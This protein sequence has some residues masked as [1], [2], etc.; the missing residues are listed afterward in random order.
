[1]T[2]MRF[3]PAVLFTLLISCCAARAEDWPQF[4]GP[5]GDGQSTSVGL[6]TTWGGFRRPAWRTT[7][8]GQGWSSPIVIGNRIWVTSAE[9]LALATEELKSKLAASP[10]HGVDFQ[11]HAKATMFAV[12][13]EVE[14]G[15][16]L[17][18]I[19]LLDVADPPAIHASNSYASP[20][21]VG[22]GQRV[23]CHFGSLGTVCFD[24][25]SGSILWKQRMY[26]DEITGPGS[27]P[28]LWRDRLII[29]CDGADQQFVVALDSR[30]GKTIWKTARPLIVAEDDK[31]R[32]AFS[33]PLVV[34]HAGQEQVIIPGAQ[35]V[36]AYNPANG[37]EL[38]RVKI[39][40]GHATA[41]R[42]V[43]Y[44]GL[45]FVCT[46]FMK[47]ELW[48]IR[49]DGAGDVS[50]THVAWKYDKQVPEISSPIIV[51]EQVYFT[52]SL[53]VLTCL[54]AKSGELAW[55]R[56]LGGNYSASPLFADGKLYFTSEEGL[57]TVV[58]PGAEYHELARNQLFGQTKA[59]LAVCGQS[60]L[61][62]T[63]PVLYCLG[64][65]K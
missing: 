50:A 42:P 13:L 22:D 35:W 65:S 55:Q 5:T 46:G 14:N 52:S 41:P 10:A 31:L 54:N 32:R 4:R 51:G 20:T 56:R 23:Y 21:P 60:L 38:W 16:I 59:S 43:A 39:G 34:S 19:D 24:A 7:I 3:L 63:D 36:A 45:V 62:R 53:G 40:D 26:F 37:D 29:P 6:P 33:T 47:P 8:P 44:G 27:S 58:A 25:G 57:T 9:Q 49:L 2:P 64:G 15:E 18:R 1:M 28:L 48:A 61:I 12:E 30:T 17:R 11:A